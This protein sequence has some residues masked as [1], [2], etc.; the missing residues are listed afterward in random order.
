MSP[1]DISCLCS[2][3][4]A[5]RSRVVAIPLMPYTERHTTAAHPGPRGHTVKP[6]GPELPV[7][8]EKSHVVPAGETAVRWIVRVRILTPGG[9]V[10]ASVRVAHSCFVLSLPFCVRLSLS[11]SACMWVSLSHTH[12][13]TYEGCTKIDRSSQI[14]R[15]AQ[16]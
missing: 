1:V 14:T 5:V 7:T 3:F 13:H 12:T 2:E 11:I 15:H 10:P 9:C 16:K 8:T 6:R 4:C